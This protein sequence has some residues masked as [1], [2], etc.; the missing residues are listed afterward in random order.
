[1]TLRFGNGQLGKIP[2]GLIVVSYRIGGGV[3]GNVGPGAVNRID[4]LT[5][6][7]A[8]PVAATVTNPAGPYVVGR[9]RETIAEI[10][11]N[12]PASV[13]VTNRTVTAEDY[14]TTAEQ[15][16]GVARAKIIT[17]NELPG[18]VP[19]NTG[20][21]YV[22]PTDVGTPSQATLD[23]VLEAV[24]T[25]RPK[26]ITFRPIV[27]AA[28]Y[29][30]IDVRAVVYFAPNTR[31]STVRASIASALAEYFAPLLPDLTRNTSVGFGVDY[32]PAEP[33]VPLSLLLAKVQDV[34]GVARVGARTDD[35][36][37]A[38]EHADVTLAAYEWPKL[39][40]LVVING[41]TGAQ[42]A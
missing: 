39:G 8:N 36:L 34:N 20:Y 5:D 30:V 31:P 16:S 22:V 37:L 18:A 3:A 15:V 28:V 21:I 12:A 1:V 29:K 40:S 32:D 2:E 41:A 14:E 9:E 38:G 25:T 24:T 35:F 26:T 23:A 13:R 17:S 6:V 33:A 10:K 4:P 27:L 11:Q 42:V 19:E 7:L